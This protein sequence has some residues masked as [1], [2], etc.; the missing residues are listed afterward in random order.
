MPESTLTIENLSTNQ[1]M[2]RDGGWSLP[3][4][5]DIPTHVKDE[6]GK[7]KVNPNYI[8][9]FE[10]KIQCDDFCICNATYVPSETEMS[11]KKSFSNDY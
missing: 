1:G 11:R 6:D 3:I 8:D 4:D 7:W 10:V 5:M 2:L 9:N